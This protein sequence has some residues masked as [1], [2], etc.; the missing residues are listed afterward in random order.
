MLPKVR[1]LLN[2][3]NNNICT[4]SNKLNLSNDR[5]STKSSSSSSSNENNGNF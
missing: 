4:R 5:L 2:N 1:R 3:T